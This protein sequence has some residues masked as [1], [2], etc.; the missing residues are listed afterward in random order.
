MTITT[1]PPAPP[2]KQTMPRGEAPLPAMPP[3]Q[4]RWGGVVWALVWKEFR[5]VAIWT[6][7]AMGVFGTALAYV[8]YEDYRR[9]YG[10]TAISEGFR[11]M[12]TVVPPL[13]AALLGLVQFY[14]EMR[15][16]RFG[17]L[18]H[19]PVSRSVLFAAKVGVGVA[20]YLAAMILP[21]MLALL[22]V[23]NPEH[24]ALPFTWYM[25]WSPV[26]DIV[27]AV[28]FY[29]AGALVAQRVDARWLGSRLL[30]LGA[31]VCNAV[32]DLHP[33]SLAMAVVVTALCV[34]VLGTSAWSHYRA[35]G[36]FGPQGRVAKALLVA[37][38]FAGFYLVGAVGLQSVDGWLPSRTFQGEWRSVHLLK[39]GTPVIQHDVEKPGNPNAQYASIRTTQVEDLAGKV[40]FT[41]PEEQL[42]YPPAG[43]WLTMRG[44]WSPGSGSTN[45]RQS[46]HYFQSRGDMATGIRW[47]L[48]ASHDYLVGYNG[49]YPRGGLAGALGVDGFERGVSVPA[50]KFK[51]LANVSGPFNGPELQK[52]G[53]WSQ[54][55][56]TYYL[57]TDGDT[58]Y[59]F[60]E[61]LKLTV[62]YMD[63]AHE[64]ILGDGVIAARLT[65]QALEKLLPMVR[66]ASAVTILSGM[67]HAQPILRHE[68]KGS[69]DW[70]EVGYLAAR[71]AFLFRFGNY[72]K[73]VR[74]PSMAQ[75]VRRDGQEEP[76][77]QLP[78]SSHS[79]TY[80]YPW[81][82]AAVHGLTPPLVR[83]L[84][85][86][87]VWLDNPQEVEYAVAELPWQLSWGFGYA[88]A[89]AVVAFVIGWRRCQS[90][91]AGLGWAGMTALTGVFGLL[92]LV[93]AGPSVPWAKCPACGHRRRVDNAR[94]RGCGAAASGPAQNGTEVM[95][96]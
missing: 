66:T 42:Y 26:V 73:D 62:L 71:D 90:A 83:A 89:A 63:P 67:D 56:D 50:R 61:T 55:H 35:A 32:Y 87:I 60:D 59:R 76:A 75:V 39:D 82:A 74:L 31:A 94:C 34:G 45:P 49:G 54:A 12:L 28:P 52:D 48:P 85:V 93:A 37:V 25:A 8:L 78:A 91:G 36:Q 47:F 17:L 88:L 29:L 96:G 46:S 95:S 86:A 27:S 84:K 18:T 81:Q 3:R 23:S 4:A 21:L 70:V 30:P 68:L 14:W 40:L 53:T 44:F 43:Q 5:E 92:A 11:S 41:I 20:L 10:E 79:G 19:R 58:L 16:G 33:A 13:A 2:M 80:E 1:N 38:L 77:V 65:P 15:P 7:L 22:W 51:H 6:A 24:I 64:N 72:G 9:N 69:P 57:I